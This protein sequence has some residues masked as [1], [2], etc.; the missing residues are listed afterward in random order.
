MQFVGDAVM[1]VFGAPFADKDHPVHALAAANAM[2]ASQSVV[3]EQWRSAGLAE[4]PIGIGLSS[5]QVAAALLGS[6]EHLEYT[7]VGDTVNLA[8]RLQQFSEAGQT[9]LSEATWNALGD[10]PDAEE[11]PAAPIKGR[12]ALVRAWRVGAARAE[13]RAATGHEGSGHT[14]MDQQAEQAETT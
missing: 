14:T 7:L 10:R 5:G 9:T 12:T 2:H 4:F 13:R 6:S 3:N 8:Q 1:A 11:I